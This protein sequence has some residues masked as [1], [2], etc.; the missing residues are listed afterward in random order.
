VS[1][2]DQALEQA[3]EPGDIFA[4]QSSGG[5]VEQEQ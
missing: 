4:V 2:L 1:A 3:E 5:L